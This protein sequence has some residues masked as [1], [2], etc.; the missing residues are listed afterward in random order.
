MKRFVV[1][2]SLLLALAAAG[3][4][5]CGTTLPAAEFTLSSPDLQSGS[6]DNKFVLNGFGCK[7]ENISPTLIW[8]N[9][10]AGTKSFALQV[11]DPDAPTGSGFWHWAVYNIP[12]T[13]VILS[14]GVG[15]RPERLPAGAFGGN[16]DFMDTG[17]LAATA[18]TVALAR[19]R[20]T[21]RTAMSSRSTRWGSTSWRWPP[22]C[23]EP[24]APR[25]TASCSTRA[26]GKGCSARPASPP[27]TAADRAPAAPAALAGAAKRQA[28]IA[29]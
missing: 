8:R 11:Y 17:P 6:F 20:A 1:P 23:P 5:G 9:P 14:Q 24:A 12:P 21:G 22:A 29:A 25:C 4:S 2:T 18:T 10:P 7:G 15:N 16:T 26:S 3:L 13:T 19:R 28:T 27:P